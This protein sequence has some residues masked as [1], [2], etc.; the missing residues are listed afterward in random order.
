MAAMSSALTRME[1]CSVP[2]NRTIL[3]V[4]RFVESRVLELEEKSFNGGR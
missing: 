1:E 4:L 3:L 2:R